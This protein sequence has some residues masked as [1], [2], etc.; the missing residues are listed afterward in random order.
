MNSIL[1]LMSALMLVGIIAG[2]ITYLLF[3]I[4]VP[5]LVS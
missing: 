4:V 5:L 3:G 2:T 1:R